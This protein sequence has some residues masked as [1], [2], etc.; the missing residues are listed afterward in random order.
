MGN[1]SNLSDVKTKQTLKEKIQAM[2]KAQK[3]QLITA[4]IMTVLLII[5]MPTFAW[6]S[7]QKQSI[8]NNTSIN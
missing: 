8:I 1:N 5:A 4:S 6:F 2:D 7:Y 3:I